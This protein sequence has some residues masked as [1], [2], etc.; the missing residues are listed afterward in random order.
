MNVSVRFLVSEEPP[1]CVDVPAGGFIGRSPFATLHLDDPRV[2]E[3]HALVSLR[4]GSLYLLALRRR[5]AVDGR[6][7][8][9]LR[10]AEGQLIELAP[11]LTLEVSELALPQH[12]PMLETPDGGR[13]LLPATAFFHGDPPRV[14]ASW[15]PEAHAVLWHSPT[16][17]RLRVRGAPDA[18]LPLD[19]EAPSVLRI[20]RH[21]YRVRLTPLSAIVG[22]TTLPPDP[23]VMQVDGDHVVVHSGARS[24]TFD[25]VGA[26]LLIELD[27]APGPCAW[28]ALAQAVWPS[29]HDWGNLRRRLDVTL[30]RVRKKLR[31]AGLPTDFVRTEGNGSF[32]LAARSSPAEPVPEPSHR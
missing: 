6:P 20:G 14:S 30:S 11:E 16:G 17:L 2:S 28:P 32:S 31:D 9:E 22:Q 26:R 18:V 8:D 5:F 21:E 27:A 13:Q 7:A 1:L 19:G 12:V 3:A 23:L 10:L 15:V 24:A 29:E 25:G 4:H